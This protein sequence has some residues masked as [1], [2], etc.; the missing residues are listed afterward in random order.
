MF[1]RVQGQTILIVLVYVDDILV[2]SNDLAAANSFKNYLHDQI[3][4]EDLGPLKFF[5]GLEI[6]RTAS[7]L[8][9]TKKKKRKKK[10]GRYIHINYF[11]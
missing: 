10:R 7:I 8:A 6:A 5:L 11:S 2:A 1:T 3:K 9:T 4:L